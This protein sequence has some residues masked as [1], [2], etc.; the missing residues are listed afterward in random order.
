MGQ[1]QLIPEIIHFTEVI[2]NIFKTI[3]TIPFIL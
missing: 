3:G 2:L 1:P